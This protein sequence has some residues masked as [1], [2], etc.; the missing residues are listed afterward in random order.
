MNALTKGQI[1][2]WPYYKIVKLDKTGS[3]SEGFLTYSQIDLL[4]DI[5]SSHA[6][7]CTG[8][9]CSTR[10]RIKLLP[11]YTVLDYILVEGKARNKHRPVNE[12][13]SSYIEQ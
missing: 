6:S 3:A 11:H 4:C 1:K 13:K 9:L 7:L 10:A 12:R 2:E 5:W 8:E